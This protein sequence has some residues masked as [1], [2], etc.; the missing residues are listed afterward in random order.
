[1][2]RRC[3]G[4]PVGLEP[5]GLTARVR[6]DRIGFPFSKRELSGAGG[7]PRNG[8]GGV[9]P[10]LRH[11]QRVAEIAADFA[12]PF[13]GGDVAK[14]A[15]LLHDAGKIQAGFQDYLRRLEAGEKI[16]RGP[17]HAIWGATY[18]YLA[19]RQ[20]D[21]WAQIA[22]PVFG[23]H[24][25]LHAASDASL[26]L[27]EWTEQNQQ[28][29]SDLQRGLLES[30]L[31]RGEM[32]STKRTGTSLEMFIRMVFSALTD[33]DYLATEEHFDDRKADARGGGDPSKNF[34]N[35]FVKNK[36]YSW[37]IVPDAKAS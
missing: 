27:T 5:E 15:G 4:G 13:G 30:G 36:Q 18:A 22:L 17:Q 26:R 16:A 25:G 37:Q 6:G 20:T 7:A 10:L 2:R 11:L 19:L 21:L 28:D 33:A 29:L 23:H 32:S 31:L 9:D 24:A 12:S 1:M 8:R 3:T 14:L 35:G 34:W